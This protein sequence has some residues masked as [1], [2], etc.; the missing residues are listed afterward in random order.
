MDVSGKERVR[1]LKV[2]ENCYETVLQQTYNNADGAQWYKWA[3]QRL[4]LQRCHR[5]FGSRNP[6]EQWFSILKHRIKRIYK[7]WPWNANIETANS[8][9]IMFVSIFHF[10]GGLS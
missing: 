9:L 1:S 5:T 3:L 8:W 4:G 7:R 6:I 2:Y 10:I